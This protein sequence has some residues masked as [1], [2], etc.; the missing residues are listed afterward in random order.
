[1]A[2]FLSGFIPT[3]VVTAMVNETL[4]KELVFAN[5]IMMPR[6]P[7][8]LA[9]GASYKVPNVGSITVSDYDGSDI[10]LQDVT[11]GS[12]AITVNQQ[13]YFNINVDMVDSMQ[14]AKDL[15]PL[16]TAEAAYELA[17]TE[18]AYI[19]SVLNAGASVNNTSIFGAATAQ[20]LDETNIIEWIGEVKTAF[21][22]NNVPKAGR[23]L[24]LPSFAE[25]S[26]AAANVVTAAT[27]AE[28]ARR[29]GYLRNFFGFD[30]YMSN[31]L[32]S[33]TDPST[34]VVTYQALAGIGRSAAAVHSV[35]AIEFYKPEK[36]FSSAAKGLN[37]YGASVLRGDATATLAITKA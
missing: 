31:N 13:K 33:A 4:K 37:V 3:N 28:D 26:L 24:V 8:E 23:W 35:Q 29:A 7:G 25:T 10:S 2:N 36:R 9:P 32:V 22:L 5:L 30:I 6:V 1:M 19:A 14:Q 21:D 18:D 11:D 12:T 27:V 17:S 15:L 34:S 16:F 20:S